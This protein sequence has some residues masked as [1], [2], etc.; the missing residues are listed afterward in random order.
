MNW[1]MFIKKICILIFSGVISAVPIFWMWI[2]QD[3]TLLGKEAGIS[4][5]E[6]IFQHTDFIYVLVGMSVIVLADILDCDKKK[7]MAIGLL[8]IILIIL[9]VIL[10]AGFKT[11]ITI[12]VSFI[13]RTNIICVVITLMLSVLSYV[14]LSYERGEGND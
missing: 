4:L 11:N 14:I 10:F 2:S 7:V 12:H 5:L 8:Y 13:Q 3:F 9:E 6:Y 1:E